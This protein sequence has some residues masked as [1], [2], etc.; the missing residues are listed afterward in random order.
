M[1]G[2]DLPRRYQCRLQ[3]FCLMRFFSTLILIDVGVPADRRRDVLYSIP[4]P[5]IL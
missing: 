5:S 4:F 3:V 1:C 2:F